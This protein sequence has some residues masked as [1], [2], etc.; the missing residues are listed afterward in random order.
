MSFLDREY[1]KEKIRERN[2]YSYIVKLISI[3]FNTGFL[4]MV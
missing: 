1:S 2:F 3:Q 4:N